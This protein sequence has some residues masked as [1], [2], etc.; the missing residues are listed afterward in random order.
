MREIGNQNRE[1]HVGAEKKKIT[2]TSCQSAS[3]PSNCTSQ[4]NQDLLRNPQSWQVIT[5][6]DGVPTDVVKQLIFVN[7]QHIDIEGDR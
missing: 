5:P 3:Y 1:R 4:E 2:I 6:F 7:L